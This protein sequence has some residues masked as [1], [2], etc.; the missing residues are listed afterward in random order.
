MR[1]RKLHRPA[2]ATLITALTLVA[3]PS[4]PATAAATSCW[5]LYDSERAMKRETNLSRINHG[6]DALPLDQDLSKVARR[7]SQKMA[8]ANEPFHSGS[9]AFSSLLT[10]GWTLLHENVGAAGVDGDTDPLG[11]IARLQKAFM[12]SPAHRENILTRGSD[13][14][15][16]GIVRRNG[17]L[18]VTVLLVE[19]SNPGTTL[20]V[21]T[22]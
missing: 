20:R 4:P 17:Q 8:D 9:N 3:L 12:A 15:G 14:L 22:C 13:Y 16:I 1:E 10:G 19:G 21:P 6:L 5:T 7:H 18:F 2:I 11:E